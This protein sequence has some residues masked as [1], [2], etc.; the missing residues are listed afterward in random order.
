MKTTGV[1]LGYGC[2]Y[3]GAMRAA[4]YARQSRDKKTSIEQQIE[5][6]RAD[7]DEH[8]WTLHDVYQDGVSAS[9]FA[10][11]DR[12]EWTRLLAALQAGHFKVLWVW[13]ASRGDR[14]LERWA[15]LLRLCRDHGTKIYV[16]VDER[17][18]DLAITSDWKT[19]AEAGVDS[20]VESEKTSKRMLRSTA[21]RAKAGRPHGFAAY[22]YRRTPVLDAEGNVVLTQHSTV[23]MCDV[24]DPEQA[25]VIQEATTR[26]LN[27]ESM[28]SIVVDFNARGLP[29]P[30]GKEW[31]GT[32]LRQI[33]LR[34]RNAGR[35]VHRVDRTT[36]RPSDVFPA[37]WEP[38]VSSDE[39]DRLKALLTDPNRRQARGNAP[40]HLL[41]GIAECGLCGDTL[42]GTMRVFSRKTRDGKTAPAAYCCRVCTRIRRKQANVDAVVAAVVVGR[43]SL[44]D[45]PDLLAGD[46]AALREATEQAEALQARL[47]LAADQYADGAINAEQLERITARLRPQIA[48]SQARARAAAPSPEL[49]D[50]AH[51]D[52]IETAWQAAPL[53]VRRAIVQLL[54][55]VIIEPSG[56]GSRFDPETVRIEW[57]QP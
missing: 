54:C 55:R 17:L 45:G 37:E 26:V 28:R 20:A 25:A 44:P 39:F 52:S 56:K 16:H 38:I 46:P 40:A 15:R 24:L 23:L 49:A 9:R 29:S 12:P 34:E 32:T 5:T 22:G 19:L 42:G 33:L 13:E 8:G 31:E 7:A 3:P 50:V 47:N 35:R 10:T 57:K 21:A 41:S 53:H 2:Y 6:G 36:G 30:R 4:L 18:Y 1:A 48:E 11:K 14:D 43:L 51:A 27:R